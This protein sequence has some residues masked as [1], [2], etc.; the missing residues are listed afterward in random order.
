MGGL[1]AVHLVAILNSLVRLSGA[2]KGR[3]SI[4]KPNGW[5]R[6]LAVTEEA[7]T[8]VGQRAEHV[9]CQKCWGG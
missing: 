2:A 4:P 5:Q 1:A 3:G 9:A 8:L 7:G 6:P